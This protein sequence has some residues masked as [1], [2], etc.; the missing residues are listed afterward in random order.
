MYW[1]PC[2]GGIFLEEASECLNRVC[3]IWD[4]GGELVGESEEGS[5]FGECV[6]RGEGF[7]CFYF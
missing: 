7:D 4:E 3:E 5:K 2:E 6:G 1:S